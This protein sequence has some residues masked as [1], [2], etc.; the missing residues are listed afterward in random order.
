MQNEA[1]VFCA[2]VSRFRVHRLSDVGWEWQAVRKNECMAEVAA[3]LPDLL[4]RHGRYAAFDASNPVGKFGDDVHPCYP[5]I[6]PPNIPN[7]RLP[8]TSFRR[9]TQDF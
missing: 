7:L 5:P 9:C 4:G 1:R 2:Q 6:S 8:G 3:S